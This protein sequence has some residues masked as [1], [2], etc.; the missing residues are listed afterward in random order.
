M[1][2]S[3]STTLVWW[4]VDGGTGRVGWLILVWL[5]QGVIVLLLG[6]TVTVFYFGM[7]EMIEPFHV[8]TLLVLQSCM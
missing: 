8:H 7:K 1:Y 4:L 6:W 5:D 3:K 2:I